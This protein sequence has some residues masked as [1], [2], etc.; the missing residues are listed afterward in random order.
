MSPK[1]KEKVFPP[2]RVTGELLSKTKECSVLSDEYMSDYIRKAVEMRN[3]KV[4]KGG[5]K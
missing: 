5:L 1:I 2:V 3:E 4:R